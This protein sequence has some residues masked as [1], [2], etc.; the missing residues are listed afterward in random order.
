M[1]FCQDL[2]EYVI[3]NESFRTLLII[4]LVSQNEYI[5]RE[6]EYIISDYVINFIICYDC[7]D[8]HDTHICTCQSASS[9]WLSYSRNMHH[10]I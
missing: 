1:S 10:A 7:L 9:N 8:L 3:T 5:I 6:Y 2:I 4:T